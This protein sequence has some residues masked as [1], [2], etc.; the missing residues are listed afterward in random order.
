M[1]LPAFQYVDVSTRHITRADDERLHELAL[2]S[3]RGEPMNVSGPAIIAQY[4]VGYFVGIPDEIGEEF[5]KA[6]NVSGALMDLMRRCSEQKVF[7]L[8][9]DRDGT[10]HDDLPK[11]DW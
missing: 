9:I 3:I 10:R 2:E 7:V 6:M 11:F 5:V 1:K 4:D 8:R